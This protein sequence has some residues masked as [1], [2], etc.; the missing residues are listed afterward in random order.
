MGIMNK[1]SIE[2]EQTENG[3][4]FRCLG[5]QVVG[6]EYTDET[7]AWMESMSHVCA[8]SSEELGADEVDALGLDST[9]RDGD[10]RFPYTEAK[11]TPAELASLVTYRGTKVN[12]RG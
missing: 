4:R 10:P 3:W 1:R 5:D 9:G 2:V 6:N 7:P 11:L 8:G 12:T